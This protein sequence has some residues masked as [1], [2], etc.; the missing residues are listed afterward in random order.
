MYDNHQ[1]NAAI[2]SHRKPSQPKTEQVD[3]R[4]DFEQSTNGADFMT[5]PASGLAPIF[6]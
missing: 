6:P 5:C 1:H 4:N 3:E 2:Q